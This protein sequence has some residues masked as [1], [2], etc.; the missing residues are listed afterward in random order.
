MQWCKTPSRIKARKATIHTFVLLKE[1]VESKIIA[2]FV[3]NANFFWLRWISE[4]TNSEKRG[5]KLARD[6]NQIQNIYVIHQLIL[7]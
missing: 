6:D 2:T 7:K 4:I 3:K 1:M 5:N